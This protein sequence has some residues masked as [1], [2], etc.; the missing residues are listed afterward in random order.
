M[1]VGT[2]YVYILGVTSHPDGFWTTQQA[3]SLLMKLDHR[4]SEF[5]FL[6]RDRA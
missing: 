3:R 6:V 5:T 2:R 4:A 1:E